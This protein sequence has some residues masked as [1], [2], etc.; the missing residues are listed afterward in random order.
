MKKCHLETYKKVKSRCYYLFVIKPKDLV[1]CNFHTIQKVC[2]VSWEQKATDVKWRLH[3]AQ[4][5]CT[6]TNCSYCLS[7]THSSHLLNLNEQN[8]CA[9]NQSL[10]ALAGEL[11]LS[12]LVIL[13]PP[14]SY[15]GREVSA[16]PSRAKFLSSPSVVGNLEEEDMTRLERYRTFGRRLQLCY[17]PEVQTIHPLYSDKLVTAYLL[18]TTVI[19]LMPIYINILH[20]VSCNGQL[21]YIKY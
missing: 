2:K 17:L 9:G 5:W 13:Q 7:F 3:S 21:H 20:E 8:C 12:P 10:S 15:R 16:G 14:L 18:N 1:V 4:V 6:T 11:N 19:L